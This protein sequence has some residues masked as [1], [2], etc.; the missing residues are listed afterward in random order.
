[1]TDARLVAESPRREESADFNRMLKL[2]G[3]RRI[4][5]ALFTS[6]LSASCSF[7]SKKRGAKRAPKLSSSDFRIER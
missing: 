5:E 2:T 1:V 7:D 6:N 3:L 4:P